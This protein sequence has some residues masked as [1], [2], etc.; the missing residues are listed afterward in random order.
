M[1]IM[2]IWILGLCTVICLAIG[3]LV[4][5]EEWHSGKVS[6]KVEDKFRELIVSEITEKYPPIASPPPKKYHPNSWVKSRQERLQKE[7]EIVGLM[8]DVVKRYTKKNQ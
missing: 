1:E 8:E 6:N 2:E 3:V 7:Q 4:I 5:V